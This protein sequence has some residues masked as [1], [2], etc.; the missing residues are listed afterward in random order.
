MATSMFEVVFRNT[1][2]LVCFFMS[3]VVIEAH[4][5][6]L[7]VIVERQEVERL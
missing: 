3:F 5:F 2:E 1:G 4:L 6:C 7:G